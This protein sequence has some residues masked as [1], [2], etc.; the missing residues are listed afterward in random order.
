MEKIITLT[1]NLSV[2]KSASGTQLYSRTD[3]ELLN[4][5]DIP[6]DENRQRPRLQ[7]CS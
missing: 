1:A 3:V 4:K 6:R 7:R 2:E 5:G